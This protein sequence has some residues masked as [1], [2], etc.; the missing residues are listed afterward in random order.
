M[1][2]IRATSPINEL[3]LVGSHNF[4]RE[5]THSDNNPEYTQAFSEYKAKYI[6]NL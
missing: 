4:L 3:S 6:D 1:H 2:V 5:L